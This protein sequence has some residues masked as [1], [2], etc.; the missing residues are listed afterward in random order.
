ME[1]N[2]TMPRIIA[3]R[4]SRACVTGLELFLLRAWEEGEA[5]R[6]HDLRTSAV[7][8]LAAEACEKKVMNFVSG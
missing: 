6:E 8:E 3:D 5:G 4:V 2:T 1:A 7:R